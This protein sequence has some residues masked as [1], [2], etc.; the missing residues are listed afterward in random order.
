MVVWDELCARIGSLRAA[1]IFQDDEVKDALKKFQLDI[2]KD[3]AHELGWEFKDGDGHIEQQFKSL[4]FGS[5][6][7][8]S[9]EKIKQAAFDMFNKF[10]NGDRIAIHPNLRSSVYAIVLVNGGK[11]EYEV[12]LNEYRNA[13]TSAERNTALRAIGRAKDPELIKRTLDYALSSE[14]K[15]QDIYLPLGGLRTH[16]DGIMALWEW[17]KQNWDELVARLPPGLS[18]LGSVVAICTSSFTNEE[19]MK[20]IRAFYDGKSTKGFD[21]ALAQSLDAIKAKE[22]WLE[23]DTE[24]VKDWLKQ[25]KYL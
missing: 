1:W 6:G 20:D 7:L 8:A 17:M 11:E 24:D 21:Q 25:N 13:K 22:N 5:A 3:K 18:M 23:R 10:K 12:I 19:H 14:V 16:K 15:G 9:D 2:V 4:L